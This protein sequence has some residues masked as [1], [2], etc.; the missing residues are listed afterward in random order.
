MAF[1]LES[2]SDLEQGSKGF[3]MCKGWEEYKGT[4]KIV[5]EILP[6]NF[7]VLHTLVDVSPLGIFK[8]A[9]LRP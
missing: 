1:A 5:R 6:A 2:C 3:H 9:S 7:V 8:R 4:G